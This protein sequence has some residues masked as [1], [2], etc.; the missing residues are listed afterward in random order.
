VSGPSTLAYLEEAERRGASGCGV[1][2]W[3]DCGCS[4][5]E[6]RFGQRPRVFSQPDEEKTIA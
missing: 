5:C 1:I 3:N 4:I 6:A 2:A